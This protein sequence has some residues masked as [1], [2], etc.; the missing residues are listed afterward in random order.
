[1]VKEDLLESAEDQEKRVNL[2]NK[3]PLVQLVQQVQEVNLVNED[4]RELLALMV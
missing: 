1:M 2:E 4:S 3:D